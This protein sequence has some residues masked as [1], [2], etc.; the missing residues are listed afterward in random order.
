MSLPAPARFALMLGE[1]AWQR[2]AFDAHCALVDGVVQ[3]ASRSAA[4]S[5]EE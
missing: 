2:A 4:M 1:P 5:G 3:L